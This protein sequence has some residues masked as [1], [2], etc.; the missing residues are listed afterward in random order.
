MIHDTKSMFRA[1]VL[2]HEHLAGRDAL[3]N[4]IRLPEYTWQQI[5]RLQRQ[6]LLAR[7]RG[8]HLANKVL[9]GELVGSLQRFQYELNKSLGKVATHRPF[10]KSSS[11][12]D[13]F[14]D[15]RALRREF[16]DVEIDIEEQE[17]SVTTD[18]IVL[19]HIDFGRFDI[20][21]AWKEIGSVKQPYRV[22]A[23]DP[24]PAARNESVTHPHVQDEC[25]CE[26]DG[27][28]AVASALADSR[29]YDFFTL[30][31]QI[32]HTYGR[33]SAFVE[34]DRWDGAVCEECGDTMDE[35][36]RYCCQYCDST[37][38]SS[39]AVS[40]NGC[41]NSYCSE[42]RRSC[43]ACGEDYCSSCLAVC[44]RCRKRFCNAC[45]TEGLCP[46]CHSQTH[47]EDQDD[48]SCD[49]SQCEEPC[50]VGQTAKEPATV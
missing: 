20:R 14:R 33:G 8:W 19:E 5:Q 40:C 16:D 49:D 34:I 12:A 44:R 18:P 27:R 15:L 35:D 1:A 23:L 21:L 36:E 25:L 2:I 48:D 7:Q 11:P 43:A 30:V 26:G 47:E 13:I 17:I 31:S 45:V 10:R 29:I 38:C 32:L 6:A 28:A 4:S 39:C 41:Q 50:L 42:C 24:R 3:A 22:V 46:S 37:L 9:Y